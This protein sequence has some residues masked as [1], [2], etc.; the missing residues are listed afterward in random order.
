MAVTFHIVTLFPNTFKS[1][2][3]ESI[4]ARAIKEKRIAVKFYNPR[5]FTSDKWARV[6]RRPYGGGPG[7]VLEA[8]AFV[9]AIEAA[10]RS[11]KLKAKSYKLKARVI[12]FSTQG[13]SFSNVY[14]RSAVRKYTDLILV[15]GRYEGIDARVKKI[16]KAEEFSVGPYVLTGGELPAMIAIDA[17]SRQIEGVL[18]NFDSV[19]ERRIASSEVYTRPEVLTYKGKKYRVPRVLLSGNHAKITLWRN[20]NKSDFR[21]ESFRG[22]KIDV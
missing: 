21:P 1:Y 12:I 18:G 5:D 14:A 4:V 9:K 10:F 20:Q 3:G 8:P 11:A 2:L 13:K 22:K 15:C 17:I 19:E 6:D 16:F 7:M